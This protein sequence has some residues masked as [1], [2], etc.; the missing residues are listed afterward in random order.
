MRN[1]ERNPAISVVIAAFRRPDVLPRAVASVMAQT[2]SNWELVVSDDEDPPGEVWSY[3]NR[4]ARIEAR[5]RLIRNTRQH[6]QVANRNSALRHASAPW[7]KILDHDDE[8]LPNCLDNF[9]SSVQGASSAVMACCTAN[10]YRDGKLVTTQRRG[11]AAVELL[12]QRD[13]HLAMYLQETGPGHP[14]LTMVQRTVI[15][16]G[17]LFENVPGLVSAVDSAWYAQVLRHG[18]LVLI[19]SP[20]VNLHQDEQTLTSTMAQEELDREYVV[21]R[22]RQLPLIDPSLRPPRLAT[23]LQMLWLI[24]AA[25]RLKRRRFRDALSLVKGAR[26]PRA[27]LLTVR[28]GLQVVFPGRFRRIRYVTL[29]Q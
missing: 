12:R 15:A 26:D 2:F 21:L 25:N 5:L 11:Q 24:R 27:W 8:L 13:A 9:L 20:L 29:R 6:G 16:Q 3:L 23:T 19:N 22:E 4:V 7:I 10:F 18:D 28:W 14:S 17:T 1:S